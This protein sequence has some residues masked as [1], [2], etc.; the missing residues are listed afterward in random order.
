MDIRNIFTEDTDLNIVKSWLCGSTDGQTYSL[1]ERF[2]PR[3]TDPRAENHTDCIEGKW[4]EVIGYWHF[5]KV[6]D[7][8]LQTAAEDMLKRIEDFIAE[9]NADPDKFFPKPEPYT[10]SEL[11]GNIDYWVTAISELDGMDEIRREV[12]AKAGADFDEHVCPAEFEK[13]FTEVADRYK[14][15]FTYDGRI[16]SYDLTAGKNRE[17]KEVRHEVL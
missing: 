7:P 1:G 10:L 17:G 16:S 9:V 2:L 6:D 12:Y 8:A 11:K 4:D 15:R 13:E 14:F 5:F 3:L